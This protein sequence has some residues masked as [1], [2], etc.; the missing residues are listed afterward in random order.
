MAATT[1][2]WRQISRSTIKFDLD[3]P[4]SLST[5]TSMMAKRRRRDPEPTT[6]LDLSSLTTPIRVA[7]CFERYP[8]VL[9]P[10]TPFD[11]VYHE[12]KTL[13]D[14]QNSAYSYPEM[15]VD[16]ELKKRA[17]EEAGGEQKKKKKGG[18]KTEE[19]NTSLTTPQ[20]QFHELDLAA[21]AADQHVDRS[22]IET[23]A[24]RNNDT[25]SLDRALEEKL[26]LLVK[27]KGS[28]GWTLPHVELQ[29]EDMSLRGV[30]WNACAATTR[31]CCWPIQ[32]HIRSIADGMPIATAAFFLGSRT[33]AEVA[34]G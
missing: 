8:V 10:P 25:K 12:F 21:I 3:A 30:S 29:G 13:V 23:D 5:C 28:S 22:E 20:R 33:S 4:K 16:Q 15:V 26:Y 32:C 11:K 19:D 2:A 6:P 27:V 9:P 18:K 14:V 7:T 34:S 17:A 24:D 1:R 31:C